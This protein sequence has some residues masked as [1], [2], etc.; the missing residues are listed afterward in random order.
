MPRNNKLQLYKLDVEK[1]RFGTAFIRSKP[2]ST[3]CAASASPLKAEMAIGT[4]W[5]RSTRFCA[6]TTISVGD[7]AP[8]VSA[9][10]CTVPSEASCAKAGDAEIGRAHV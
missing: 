9:L 2:P 4:S 8:D 5:I 7:R 10:C 6:V 3:F 1:V